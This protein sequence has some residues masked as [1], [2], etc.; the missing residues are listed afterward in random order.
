MFARLFTFVLVLFWYIHP[1]FSRKNFTAQELQ[2]DPVYREIRR[3]AYV[4]GFGWDFHGAASCFLDKPMAKATLWQWRMAAH[5]MLCSIK[6]PEAE[7]LAVA[8]GYPC[9]AEKEYVAFL[10]ETQDE[11]A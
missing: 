6:S 7:A 8:E 3:R 9:A 4:K 2:E 5:Q 1:P 11:Y 10:Y